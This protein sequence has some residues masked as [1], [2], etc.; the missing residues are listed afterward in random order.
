[1]SE[2]LALHG[3]GSRN[4]DTELISSD[5]ESID[6][7]R[8]RGALLSL[9]ENPRDSELL[10]YF[11]GHGASTPWGGELV[12][13]DFVPDALGVSMG[14]VMT[15]A[16]NSDARHITIILDCCYSGDV[17]NI[18]G[19]QAGPA[20]L[21][22]RAVLRDN[23]TL[24]AASRPTEPAI[25]DAG[26]GSFTRL[27][28]DGLEGAAADHL[29][30]VTALS[31]YAFASR[32][33]GGWEQRPVLKAHLTDAPPL[34]VAEPPIDQALLRSL[35][36]LF[37]RAETEVY[38]TPAHEGTRPVSLGEVPTAEQLQFDR[39]KL[40][41]NAGL[42]EVRGQPDLYFAAVDGGSVGLTPLG[43]YFWR[44]ADSHR[45]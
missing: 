6:R 41:R 14:D 44:L 33:F 7:S 11:S 12:T 26:H 29:G 28:L 23:L 32:S 8:L 22:A 45:L 1:M 25:E 31:L 39:F 42:V 13:V 34:R 30:H 18:A 38:L 10:F 15:L 20:P 16:T 21:F 36:E 37:D 4:Y 19:L 2:V 24:L 27:L 3:D 35:P 40:L 5:T 9:F 17:G 43:R